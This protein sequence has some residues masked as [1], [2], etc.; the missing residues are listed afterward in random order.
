VKGNSK[1]CFANKGHLTAVTEE[2]TLHLDDKSPQLA[3]PG[4]NQG[5]GM[6]GAFGGGGQRVAFRWKFN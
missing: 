1:V 3:Q 6:F 4:A 5:G 2:I